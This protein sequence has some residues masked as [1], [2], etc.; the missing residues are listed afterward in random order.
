MPHILI[1]DDEPYQRLLI[2][3]LLSADPAFTF[4]EADDGRHALEVARAAPPDLV[5]LDVM[6]PVLDGFAAC[7]AFRQDPDLQTIPIILITAQRKTGHDEMAAEAGA[8]ALI[9]KPYE[10][11]D[12][13]SNV[14]RALE[15][16]RK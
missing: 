1:A 12:L 6:M 9:G 5:L 8:V 14:Y 10:E 4:S 13:R 7:R 15:N 3:E 16:S 11:A 2:I